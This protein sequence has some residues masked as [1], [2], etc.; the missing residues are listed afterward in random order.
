MPIAAVF[1]LIA[2]LTYETPVTLLPILASLVALLPFF[3]SNKRV[4]QGA[5][6]C[7]RP[8]VAGV[9]HCSAF[10][11][12]HGD[13]VRADGDHSGIPDEKR[14]ERRRGAGIRPDKG[15]IE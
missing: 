14:A 2:V 5:G 1:L 13:G 3:Q 10:L 4:I 11:F 7:Q 15:E 8:F 9:C 12:R 6:H